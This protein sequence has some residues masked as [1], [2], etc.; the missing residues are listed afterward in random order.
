[1]PIPRPSIGVDPAFVLA[2]SRAVR[3]RKILGGWVGLALVALGVGCSFTDLSDLSAGG[4]TDVPDADTPASEASADP[5]PTTDAGRDGET[6]REDAGDAEAEDAGMDGS[7]ELDAGVSCGDADVLETAFAAPGIVFSS[8]AAGATLT[9]TTPDGAKVAK[10]DTTAQA[11]VG[12]KQATSQFL[13]ATNF[14]FGV[15]P[16]AQIVGIDIEVRRFA[17]SL[18]GGT[19]KDKGIGIALNGKPGTVLRVNEDGWSTVATTV[20]YG[21]A[22]DAFGSSLKGE[23]LQDMFFLGAAIAV[24]ISALPTQTQT[25][26]VDSIRMRLHYC[27]APSATH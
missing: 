16:S 20:T 4:T 22:T 5:D 17:G 10:D 15:P 11:A 24:E 18:F 12:S 2:R 1:M 8:P 21:G 6:P 23:D 7:P 27:E 25:A 13:V 14:S 9:W 19:I 3:R 26:N